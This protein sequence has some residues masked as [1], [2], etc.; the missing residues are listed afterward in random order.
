MVLGRCTAGH[1]RNIELLVQSAPWCTPPHLQQRLYKNPIRVTILKYLF[2]KTNRSRS[3]SWNTC[4]QKI[5]SRSSPWNDF[6]E[7][8]Y[9]PLSKKKQQQQ[10]PIQLIIPKHLLPKIL[11]ASPCKIKE[12]KIASSLVAPPRLDG[13]LGFRSGLLAHKVG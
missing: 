12:H 8:P 2:P 4:S 7:L 13:F 1:R 5:R 11:T 10:N 6:W 3:P 9:A